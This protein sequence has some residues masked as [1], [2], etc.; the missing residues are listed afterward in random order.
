MKEEFFI[1]KK[2]KQLKPYIPGEQTKN[3]NIIK[4]NTNENPYQPNG[5]IKSVLKKIKIKQLKFYP[6]SKCEQLKEKTALFFKTLKNQIA[7]GNGSDELIHAIFRGFFNPKES[8]LFTQ[9]TYSAYEVYAHMYGIAIKKIKMK[10]DFLIPLQ[11][12]KK[13]SAKVF[14]LTNPSAPTGTLIDLKSIEKAVLENPKKLFVIDE[15]YHDFSDKNKSALCLL[16]HH[17]N[18]IILK[19]L[20]KSFSLA[21]IRL[22]MAFAHP[23]IIEAFYKILDPYNINT[24]T[25]LIAINAFHHTSHYTKNLNK[26][27][28][29]REDFK[30]KLQQLHFKVIPSSANFLLVTHQNINMEHLYLFLK[31][32]NIL[33]R[34][35]KRPTLDQYLR[36]TIGKNRDMKK[37]YKTIKRY[38]KI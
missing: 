15:A 2:I 9:Y 14:F 5:E 13:F 37:L 1:S 33:V 31:K 12:L 4:L 6:D 24:L 34:Y 23:K 3:K 8:V 26:I 10:E 30:K 25:Q 21:A 20:S 35:F 38:E 28:N 16:P 27:K 19:T 32:K 17:N 29:T 7:F 18:L 22:G 36:I 11:V